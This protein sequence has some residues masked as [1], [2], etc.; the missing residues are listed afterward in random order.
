MITIVDSNCTMSVVSFVSEMRSQQACGVPDVG[1]EAHFH[2]E[3][4]LIWGVL[5]EQIPESTVELSKVEMI[6]EACSLGLTSECGKL[7]FPCYSKFLSAL[8]LGRNLC[9]TIYECF[10]NY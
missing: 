6:V 1:R 8:A 2:Q 5:E 7:L 10:L 9:R 3:A 4:Q